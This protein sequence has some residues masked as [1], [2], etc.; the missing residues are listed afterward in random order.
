MSSTIIFGFTFGSFAVLAPVTSAIVLGGTRASAPKMTLLGRNWLNWILAMLVYAPA[1]SAQSNLQ[2]DTHVGDFSF[3]MPEGWEQTPAQNA[4]VVTLS[5]THTAPGTST[6]IALGTYGIVV[7][8]KTSFTKVWETLQQQSHLQQVGQIASNRLPGGNDAMAVSATMV[9]Q[10]GKQWREMILLAQNA[11]RSELVLFATNDLRPDAYSSAY[12]ALVALLASLHFAPVDA[13]PGA[14]PANPNPLNSMGG[15][16]RRPGMQSRERGQAAI[17][18]I[19]RASAAQV[20]SA[21]ALDLSDPAAH[22]PKYA[23]LTIFPDGRIKRGLIQGGFDN[24]QDESNFRHGIASGGN[25]ASQWGRYRISGG[26]GN[27]VFADGRLAGQ[28]LVSGLRGEVWSLSVGQGSLQANGVTYTLLDGGTGLTLE[29]T[30]KPFGDRSQPGIR[31]TRDGEFFDEGILDTHSSTAVGVVGG[32]LAIG[33]GFSSPHAGRGTYRISNY[34]MQMNYSNGQAPEMLFF[35]EVGANR[36]SP[37]VLYIG[38]VEYRRV[39]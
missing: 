28:Q 6:I 34:G 31:F 15:A 13:A 19:Y 2:P 39:Q 21:G 38:D 22:T 23:F 11:N 12:R 5:R 37:Q 1:M 3:R 30:Y 33:Y 32:G 18:G 20:P 29:G 35:L 10:D 17:P 7:D 25:W 16:P 27:I 14:S 4:G 36:D 26:Q 8:L 24:Y 9:D